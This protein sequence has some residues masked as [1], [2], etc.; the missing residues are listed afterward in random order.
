MYLQEN[1]TSV[2]GMRGPAHQAGCDVFCLTATEARDWLRTPGS[3][4]ISLTGN[5][6]NLS[7]SGFGDASLSCGKSAVKANDL[8]VTQESIAKASHSSISGDSSTVPP[9]SVEKP[10]HLPSPKDLSTVSE[11]NHLSISNGLSIASSGSVVKSSHLSIP[12]DPSSVH[13]DTTSNSNCL[14]SPEDLS[15]VCPATPRG[16]VKGRNC[17]FAYSG[18]CN[19]SGSKA[20][21]EWIREVQ[22]GALNGLL[23]T[24][25]INEENARRR[26][27]SGKYICLVLF[28]YCQSYNV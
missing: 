17:L 13:P 7:L 19:F 3:S 6:C 16:R 14:S 28:P 20:P 18:Q 1:H 15:S 24:K 9:G 10:N 23:T 22:E 11:A 25:P 26:K 27:D 4:N 5:A 21:L 8:S 12:E 2:L